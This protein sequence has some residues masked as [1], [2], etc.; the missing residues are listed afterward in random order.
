MIFITDILPGER[1]ILIPS[2]IFNQLQIV[3]LFD[4]TD[5]LFEYASPVG[6]WTHEKLCALDIPLERLQGAD[7][8]LGNT[9]IGSTEV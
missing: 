6:G 5:V 8:Y 4:R 2:V 1:V 3:D 7:A 9:W